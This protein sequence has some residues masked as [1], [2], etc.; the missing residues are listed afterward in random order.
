MT[1]TARALASEFD[2]IYREGYERLEE[3]E[4]GGS[5]SDWVLIVGGILV[6]LYLLHRVLSYVYFRAICNIDMANRHQGYAGWRARIWRTVEL[7][8]RHG[9][10]PLW[11]THQA[12]FHNAIR[13]NLDQE[14]Q[15]VRLQNMIDQGNPVPMIRFD[16]MLRGRQIEYH[17][18][19]PQQRVDAGRQVAREV[20]RD[21]VALPQQNKDGQV[22]QAIPAQAV[23]NDY[24]QRR[25][26]QQQEHQAQ[27][28]DAGENGRGNDTTDDG[29]ERPRLM[30][31]H[32][33]T[34]VPVRR[35]NFQG[36]PAG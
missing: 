13:A 31:Y 33:P 3:V 22:A 11:F 15:R 7:V 8:L 2:E 10:V 18:Q 21:N 5:V 35:V 25:A 14:H 32:D 29:Y 16:D 12:I 19:P 6:A 28:Q 17:P 24:G 27:A 23:Q 4:E 20:R 1:T 26:V 30:V 9:W 34:P 36:L